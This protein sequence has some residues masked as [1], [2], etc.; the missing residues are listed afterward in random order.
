MAIETNIAELIN[1]KAY[2]ESLER[3]PRQ[4]PRE[5]ARQYWVLND[6]TLAELI[7]ELP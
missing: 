2:R 7:N 6:N 5:N 1:E 4:K 3:R